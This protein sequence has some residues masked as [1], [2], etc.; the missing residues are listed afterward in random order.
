MSFPLS[1]TI[2]A[3]SSHTGTVLIALN[4]TDQPKNFISTSQASTKHS[5]FIF[6]P[7]PKYWL[8][9]L[10]CTTVMVTVTIVTMLRSTLV[11]VNSREDCYLTP[12]R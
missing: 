2:M 9:A 1:L 12:Q 8:Q 11:T 3:A 7:H 4:I 10:R 5:V 6:I